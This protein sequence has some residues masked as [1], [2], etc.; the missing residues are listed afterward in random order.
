[1]LVSV[2]VRSRDEADRLRLTLTSLAQQTVSAEIIVVNDGSADHTSTV[3]AEAACW[4]PLRIV[5]HSK[6]RGRS[7]A[8]NAGAQVANGDIVVFLDGDNIASPDFVARHRAVHCAEHPLV[9]RGETFHLRGTRF[10]RD[11][12]AGIPWPDAEAWL[13]RRPSDELSRIR[14]TREEIINHFDALER[15]AAP[16]IYPGA[17]PRRL[18]ELEMDALVGHPDC[19]VLWAAASGSNL[20]VPRDHFL[21]VGGF[22]ERLDINEHRELALRLCVAGARMVPVQGARTYHLTHRSG[23]RDPLR[24]TAW[25]Q[26][27]YQAHPI[28][29]VKL[30]AIFWASLSGPSRIPREA[31]IKSLLELEAAARGDTCIDYDAIRRLIPA[32]AVLD[33]VPHSSEARLA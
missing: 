18:F 2:V 4:L 6:P 10:L 12:E 30:L 15:R 16:G 21:R 17:G 27:F 29:A 20:S 25:E 32:L 31:R 19:A 13:A 8:A 11:P 9:G 24:D 22:D 5:N 26:V 3:L 14:V 28:P 1:M 23:W 7:G 33:D